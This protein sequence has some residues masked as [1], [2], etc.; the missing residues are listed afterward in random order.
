MNRG[1]DE[2]SNSDEDSGENGEDQE[3]YDDASH[4]IASDS[5]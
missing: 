4:L 5:D 2:T 3:E 1:D